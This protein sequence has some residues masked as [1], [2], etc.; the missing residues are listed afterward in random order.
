MKYHEN[1]ENTLKWTFY[2][3][4]LNYDFGTFKYLTRDLYSLD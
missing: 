3:L 2:V 4:L 1:R